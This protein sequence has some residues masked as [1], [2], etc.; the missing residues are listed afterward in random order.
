[1]KKWFLRAKILS[2]FSSFLMLCS[3]VEAR[4]QDDERVRMLAEGLP[5]HGVGLEVA[6]FYRPTLMKGEYNIYYTDYTTAD[7]LIRKHKHLDI[8]N[9]IAELTVKVDFIWTPGAQLITR[10]PYGLRFDYAIASHVIEHVPNVIGWLIQIFDVLK[11]GGVISLAV[12]DK[13]YT[14]DAYRPETHVNEMI[15]LWLRDQ[16]I[17]SPAQIYDMLSN[18]IDVPEGRLPQEEG[19]PF[20]SLH[21]N[22]TD[23]Q[24]LDFAFHSYK[25]RTYLDIHC[26]VFTPE[27]LQKIFLK[28]HELG[29]LNA[30]ISEPISCGSEFFIRLTKL[31]D[32]PVRR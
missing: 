29:I 22:Y 18:A 11:T 28:L 32:P 2:L 10:V 23:Q 7:E 12:P 19:I 8:A 24:A 4:F 14:F 21:R 26:S 13:R 25:N 5:L 3:S 30:A 16:S 31:G 27:S 1:M 9:Q 20:E 15:D 6:P 17:P